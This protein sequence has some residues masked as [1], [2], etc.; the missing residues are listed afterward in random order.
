MST[1]LNISGMTC[2]HCQTAVTKALAVRAIGRYKSVAELQDALGWTA[3]AAA[4]SSPLAAITQTARGPLRSA[5]NTA[6]AKVTANVTANV[7]TL[8]A[9]NV[10][11]PTAPA[12]A[13]SS[14]RASSI[15]ARSPA[16]WLAV[17]A[18]AVLILSLVFLLR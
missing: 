9:A 1:E 6:A 7:A 13:P 10:A 14:Q 18:A 12:G 2:G 4:A 17:A 15:S 3:A 16:F 8:S 5:A 11:R